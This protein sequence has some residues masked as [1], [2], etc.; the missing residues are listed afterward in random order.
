MADF[1]IH[2]EDLRSLRGKVIIVTGGSSG[3]GLATVELLLGLGAAVVSGDAQPPPAPQVIYPSEGSAAFFTY[4]PTDISVWADLVRLFKRAMKIHGRV[5]H[6]FANAGV[7]TLDDDFSSLS[8]DADG[9]LQ[10]PS[11]AVLDVFLKGTINTTS[12]AI[13]HMQ[14]QDPPGG[15][16]VLN[17]SMTSPQR[18]GGVAHAV[19]EHG[20]LGFVRGLKSSLGASAL[21]IRVNVLMPGKN[22]NGVDEAAAARSSAYLMADI[23]KQGHIVYV[24]DGRCCEIEEAAMFP[25]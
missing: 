5:D 24:G 22:E 1:S 14:T 11:H 16:V 17:G 19:S 21:P 25:A 12:L 23:T 10:E 15:S 8:L 4:V 7:S 13:H 6:V 3:T 2:D 9:E 18:S 20:I